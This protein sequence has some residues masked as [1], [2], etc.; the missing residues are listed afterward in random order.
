MVNMVRAVSLTAQMCG[1]YAA[2]LVILDQWSFHR[3]SCDI[4]TNR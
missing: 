1:Y 4:A 2:L 3:R